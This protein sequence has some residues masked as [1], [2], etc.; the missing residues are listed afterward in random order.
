MLL[1]IRPL[2][3]RACR[4]VARTLPSTSSRLVPCQEAV[5]EL[6]CSRAWPSILHQ[7]SNTK[8]CQLGPLT[9][10][11]LE[12][13]VQRYFL[14]ADFLAPVVA[15]SLFPATL[16]VR[17]DQRLRSRTRAGGELPMHGPM[18][19]LRR[20]TRIRLTRSFLSQR[21]KDNP[22]PALILN[23]TDVEHGYR[24][25]ITPFKIVSLGEIGNIA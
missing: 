3:W 16:L 12:Q 18:L 13:R 8:A 4:T 25:A 11:P 17:A 2:S 22:G 20:K 5:S 24:V 23:A 14:D 21:D 6:R 7:T 10:R 1:T 15:A 9:A 19:H